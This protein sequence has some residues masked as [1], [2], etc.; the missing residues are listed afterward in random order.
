MLE[1]LNG[2]SFY[3]YLGSLLYLKGDLALLGTLK[4]ILRLSYGYSEGVC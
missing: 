3:T 1:N 2:E 4:S